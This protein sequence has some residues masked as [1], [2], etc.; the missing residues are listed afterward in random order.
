VRTFWTVVLLVAACGSSDSTTQPVAP[1]GNTDGG[2]FSSPDSS[3]SGS[4]DA[5]SSVGYDGAGV[6][7]GRVCLASDP[8]MMTELISPTACAS[9]GA[10]GLTVYLGGA[11]T[12]T[13]ADGTFAIAAPGSTSGLVWHVEGPGLVPSNMLFGDYEIPALTT[14]TMSALEAANNVTL[15][16]GEG[17][18]FAQIIHNGAGDPGTTVTCTPTPDYDTF[19]DGATATAWAQGQTG[20][21]GAAWCAGLD[22]GAGTA[23][24]R[25]ADAGSPPDV[26]TTQAQPIEAGGITFVQL[27]YP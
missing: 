13:N 2:S 14:A 19:V 27:V 23:I 16:P 3:T 4:V 8:R 12:Q 6:I 20:S 1:G 21:Y 15:V 10:G 11:N 7:S 5:G 17:S 24:V 25:A 22:A 18:I 26:L 9:S